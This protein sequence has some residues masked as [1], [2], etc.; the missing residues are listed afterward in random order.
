L[1]QRSDNPGESSTPQVFLVPLSDSIFGKKVS[2]FRSWLLQGEMKVSQVRD[3]GSLQL[4]EENAPLGEG[5]KQG[6]S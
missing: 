3:T 1:L 2:E 4:V 5:E 6:I